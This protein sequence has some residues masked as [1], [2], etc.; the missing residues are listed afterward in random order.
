MR[1]SAVAALQ[2]SRSI[3]LHGSSFSTALGISKAPDTT[4]DPQSSVCHTDLLRQN[5]TA[6]QT[7]PVE[8][9]LKN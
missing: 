8:Y 5:R 2:R 7:H 4:G 6:F 9:S 1:L 3:R